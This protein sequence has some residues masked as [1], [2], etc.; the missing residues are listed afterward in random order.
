[1][2]KFNTTLYMGDLVEY[3]EEFESDQED[4]LEAIELAGDNEQLIEAIFK[5]KDESDIET[6][7]HIYVEYKEVREQVCDDAYLMTEQALNEYLNELI[8]ED[9]KNLAS[10][11]VIDWEETRS[12][13]RSDYSDVALGG[14][15]YYWRS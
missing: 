1:M 3:I 12:S 7:Y 4:L 10:Y 8:A 14:E 5:V 11:L 6:A 9:T 2:G 15:T 13:M